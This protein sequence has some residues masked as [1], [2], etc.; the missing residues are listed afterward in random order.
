MAQL[1]IF[2]ASNLSFLCNMRKKLTIILIICILSS[3][4]RFSL[5][6]KYPYMRIAKKIYLVDTVLKLLDDDW[7]KKSITKVTSY[8]YE[9]SDDE[10]IVYYCCNTVYFENTSIENIS[11]NTTAIGHVIDLASL[12][13][14]HKC[15]I[16]YQEAIEGTLK[17]HTYL[18]WT[19]SPEISCVIEYNPADVSR[20]DILKMAASIQS[21]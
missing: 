6:S 19:I 10:P 14:I 16:N 8:T 12:K 7:E 17:D 5:Y 20:E 21:G 2:S 11:L 13:N 3:L 4:L 9:S 1:G 18:C 15:T